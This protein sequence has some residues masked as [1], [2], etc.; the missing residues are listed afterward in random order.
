[1]KKETPHT[2]FLFCIFTAGFLLRLYLAW[3]PLAYL[4]NLFIPDDAYI[5]LKIAKNIASGL[6]ITFDVKM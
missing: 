2:L 5:S 6:G 1:M 4:D 3:R